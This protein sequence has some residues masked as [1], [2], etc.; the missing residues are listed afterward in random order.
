MMDGIGNNSSEGGRSELETIV[1]S[2][3]R[4]LAIGSREPVPKRKLR[5]YPA[6]F[7]DS[8]AAGPRGVFRNGRGGAA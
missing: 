3:G 8:P 6:P 4:R 7:V 2:D 5:I 1:T